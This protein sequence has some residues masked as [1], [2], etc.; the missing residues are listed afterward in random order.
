VI[1]QCFQVVRGEAG[2][3]EPSMLR[4]QAAPLLLALC[5]PLAASTDTLRTQLNCQ[6]CQ[7]ISSLL[8]QMLQ[9]RADAE[10]GFGGTAQHRRRMMHGKHSEPNIFR[11]IDGVCRQASI[12]SQGRSDD[13]FSAPCAMFMQKHRDQLENHIF[14]AGI[15]NIRRVLCTELSDLCRPYDVHDSGEL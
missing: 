11:A 4:L 15:A 9:Q 12:A 3:Q 13:W 6:D 7:M 2:R 1:P 5:L 14:Q 10:D 8:Q